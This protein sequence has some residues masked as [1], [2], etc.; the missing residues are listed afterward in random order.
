MVAERT[1][2]PSVSGNGDTSVPPPAKESRSGALARTSTAAVLD[3]RPLRCCATG[4]GCLLGTRR[5]GDS[6]IESPLR[7]DRLARV[8]NR[9]H[10][11]AGAVAVILDYPP[12]APIS[13]EASGPPCHALSPRCSER[14]SSSVLPLATGHS[15]L[16]RC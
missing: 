9:V 6:I 13:N 7:V 3:V 8:G 11:S 4:V 14:K 15:A 2:P 1:T 5:S 16:A 10:M 12:R